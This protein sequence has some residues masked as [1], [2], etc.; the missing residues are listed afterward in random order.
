MADVVKAI[1]RFEIMKY[2]SLWNL[3]DL[4]HFALMWTGWYFWLNQIQL[5]ASLQLPTGF[6]I[7][8]HFNEE[9]L[10]RLLLTNPEKE[11]IFL[12]FLNHLQAMR[13]NLTMYSVITSITGAV[14]LCGI[15]VQLLTSTIQCFY[16]FSD[17]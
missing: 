3:I 17:A 7:L 13:K 5:N 4:S 15:S 8:N 1:R 9:T 14:K 16:L 2:F 6:A 12:S 11:Y 10:A